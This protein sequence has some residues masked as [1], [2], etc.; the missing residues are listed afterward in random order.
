M[1]TSPG[2][3]R[4]KLRAMNKVPSLVA[5]LAALEKIY[6][7]RAGRAGASKQITGGVAGGLIKIQALVAAIETLP[8][9]PGSPFKAAVPS[10][11][12]APASA[13][14]VLETYQRLLTEKP[15]E[16]GQFYA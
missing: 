13:E 7:A 1:T 10:R 5:T 8:A 4:A 2:P 3:V 12:K 15:R 9:Q 6:D 16:A 14:S 11:Q